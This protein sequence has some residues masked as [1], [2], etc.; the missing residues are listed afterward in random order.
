MNHNLKKYITLSIST[1]LLSCSPL[2]IFFTP[3]IE[4]I[5]KIS[6]SNLNESINKLS[7]KLISEI[8]KNN[9]NT[10]IFISPLNIA[11]GINMIYN[12]SEGKVKTEIENIM[13]YNNIELSTLNESNNILKRLIENQDYKVKVKIANSIWFK[14]NLNL[15]DNYSKTIKSYYQAN[16]EQLDFD[17]KSSIDRINSWFDWNTEGKIKKVIENIDKED[18]MILIN[19]MYFKGDWK[20]KFDSSQ[21]K[22]GT[23]FL[24]KDKSIETP[25]MS[26]NTKSANYMEEEKYKALKL[27]YGDGKF[28]MSIFLPNEESN[29]SE[30]FNEITQDEL[31]NWIKISSEQEG[32]VTMP[33]YS[34]EYQ[35]ELNDTLKNIGLVTPFKKDDCTDNKFKN[36]LGN[37]NNICD[38]YISKSI[39]KTSI[40]VN[41]NGS[42]I[43]TTFSFYPR[44]EV[45]SVPERFSINI[46]RPFFCFITENTTGTIMFEGVI[47]NPSS[48]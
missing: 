28:S 20:E 2:E 12:G 38:L 48:K 17:N 3:K 36:M 43:K 1:L 26:L 39:Q 8:Y 9:K 14:N 15:N 46:N 24:E 25:M 23:F 35:S 34:I 31:K 29:L 37:N 18:V 5:N 30:F 33:K 16:L 22:N 21:T 44:A 40:D 10:N 6:K 32:Y 4:E 47:N 45:T 27:Y 19:A 41:E 7:L 42:E 11:S 13:S